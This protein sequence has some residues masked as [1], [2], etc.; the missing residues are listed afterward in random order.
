MNRKDKL[1]S[2]LLGALLAVLFSTSAVA[3]AAE[4]SIEQVRKVPA[5][6][7]TFKAPGATERVEKDVYPP[8][9]T[10]WLVASVKVKADAKAS[11]Q[12]SEIVVKTADGSS[13]SAVGISTEPANSFIKLESLPL[14]VGRGPSAWSVL[15]GSSG[16]VSLAL[17]ETEAEFHL[18]FA[19]P[20]ASKPS[21]LELCSIGSAKLPAM[22]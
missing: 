1:G 6:T 14:G 20:E 9:G 21:T 2:L 3:G 10:A 22:K 18:L 11:C 13:T 12:V 4:V 15:R 7:F 8:A 19:V 17:I 5:A 16:K